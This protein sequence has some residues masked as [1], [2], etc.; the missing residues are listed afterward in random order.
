MWREAS[1]RRRGARAELALAR[2]CAPG[3][4]DRHVGLAKALVHDLP[5]TMAALTSG[6]LSEWRATIVARETACL[7]HDDRVEADRRLAG[8]LTSVGDREL[9]AAAHRAS[10]D[11]D[12]EALVRR[13]RRA[14]ASRSVSVRPAADGM[15][16]LSVLGPLQ[17]VVG[18]FAALKK[19]GWDG[20]VERAGP[21]AGC[22]RCVCGVEEGRA[23]PLRRHR[24]PSG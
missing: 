23:V 3:Q 10:A 13:R 2:R 18:A 15:A 21:V 16:W 8:C 7:S 6:E 12:A 17:D 24:R 19:A 1:C 20:V 14:V 5:H 22:G 4:A 9:A 11:L